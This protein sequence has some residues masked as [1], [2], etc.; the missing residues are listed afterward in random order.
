MTHS[1]AL[2]RATLPL[3]L[4]LILALFLL[5][6]VQVPASGA[7]SPD[8]GG[9]WPLLPRPEV[10]R[11]FEPPPGRWQPGHRG[12]DLAGAAGQTVHAPLP[13]KI[14]Y[15]APLAGRGVVVIM[16]GTT[17]T[18][19]EPVVPSVRTGQIVTTGQPIGRLS[20]AGS[21]CAPR[22][23][24]HW[25]LLQ[26]DTYLDPLSLL[27]TVPVRLL[28]S[29]ND[30]PPKPAPIDTTEA[31]PPAPAWLEPEPRSA[32]LDDSDHPA[33]PAAATP[34]LHN[35]TAA[36]VLVGVAGLLTIAGGL[37]TRRH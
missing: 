18:T 25:G 16:H 19:Y 23:C 4:S 2:S 13:G 27:G 15:A 30:D 21:H 26:G 12:V 5:G 22:A 35:T 33:P 29:N 1:R 11:G 10:V 17:R 14:T 7:A 37:A 6:L 20:S 36:A 34:G 9:R 32:G 28:P 24:L 3:T 31:R 8:P